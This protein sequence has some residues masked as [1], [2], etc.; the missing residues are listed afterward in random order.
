MLSIF[1][2]DEIIEV[3]TLYTKSNFNLLPYGIK[4]NFN[5]QKLQYNGESLKYIKCVKLD[6]VYNHLLNLSNIKTTQLNE[7]YNIDLTLSEKINR[8]GIIKNNINSNNN[9]IHKNINKINKNKFNISELKSEILNLDNNIKK[10]EEDNII[11]QKILDNFKNK[12]D[13][14]NELIEEFENVNNNIHLMKHAHKL[15]KQCIWN[16]LIHGN[17]FGREYLFNEPIIHSDNIINIPQLTLGNNYIYGRTYNGI[18]IRDNNIIHYPDQTKSIFSIIIPNNLTL[19]DISLIYFR[20]SNPYKHI[21]N[22]NKSIFAIQKGDIFTGHKDENKKDLL[23]NTTIIGSDMINSNKPSSL[24]N[25]ILSN[26]NILTTGKYIIWIQHGYGNMYY[27]LNLYTSSITDINTIFE[28]SYIKIHNNNRNII[29]FND[30]LTI[31]SNLL[32]TNYS[33]DLNYEW[34][35]DSKTVHSGSGLLNNEYQIQKEDCN[36]SI[37]VSIF[38]NHP[39]KGILRLTSEIYKIE[40]L[41][42]DLSII[43]SQIDNNILKIIIKNIGDIT[44]TKDINTG[45]SDFIN[46]YSLQQTHNH[47]GRKLS[48]KDKDFYIVDPENNRINFEISNAESSDNTENLYGDS[49]NMIV[50]NKDSIN[51]YTAHIWGSGFG[52]TT[53]NH[54]NNDSVSVLSPLKPNETIKIEIE[55][56]DLIPNNFYTLIIDDP[57]SFNNWNKITSDEGNTDEYYEIFSPYSNN[58]IIFTGNKEIISIL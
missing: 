18:E 13:N 15:D 54:T 53:I 14:N 16:E 4:Y 2:D 24:L 20:R 27:G 40:K 46:I 12:N 6:V 21:I 17:L 36:K 31:D 11:I 49:N 35:I 26:N 7:L 41:K 38:Y 30:L 43:Q 23:V 55:L 51:S 19:K 25:G 29:K 10:Y 39:L 1:T 9:R 28:K 8:N 34:I 45:L 5:T 33:Q 57:Y 52:L 48:L 22:D 37:S 56:S 58:F 50:I 44:S 42:A 47:N 32:N 3:I